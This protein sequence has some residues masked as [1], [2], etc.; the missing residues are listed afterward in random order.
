[1]RLLALFLLVSACSSVPMTED[2]KYERDVRKIEAEDG[3]LQEEADCARKS[4]V[5]VYD[6]HTKPRRKGEPDPEALRTARCEW[7]TKGLGAIY[8]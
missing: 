8:H 7:S 4:G 6:Y 5:M 3:Y 1:M 2:Q